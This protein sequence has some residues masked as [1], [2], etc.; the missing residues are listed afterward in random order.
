[1]LHCTATTNSTVLVVVEGQLN[2]R[3]GDERHLVGAAHTISI[4]A[5]V[6]HAFVAVGPKPARFFAFLP[7]QGAQA[8]TTYL[9]GDP[10]AGFGRLAE[11]SLRYGAEI[12]A[13]SGIPAD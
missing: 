10:P 3:I 9:E 12:Q 11:L 5:G 1:V 7:K 2:L 4:P 6:P 13:P 8:V